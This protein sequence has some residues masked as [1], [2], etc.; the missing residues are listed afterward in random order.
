MLVQIAKIADQY[1]E[2][3]GKHLFSPASR[4]PVVLPQKDE[5]KNQ[6]N[7]STTEVCFKCNARAHKAVNYPSLVKK[8]FV[9]G[10][11][12]QL[13]AGCLVQPPEV[14]P[15]EEEVRACIK[16]DKPLLASGKK[17]PIISNACLEPLSGDQL[18]MPVVKGRVGEK[19]V[20][21]LRDPGC[22]GIIVKKN[23]VSEDQ[24]TGDFN[25]MLLIDNTAR[26]VPIARIS[27]DTPYLKGQAEAQCLPDAIYELIIGNFSGARPQMNQTQLGKKHAL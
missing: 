12:G 19:T 7:E 18:K 15:T 17:I 14:K 22:S 13:N 2:A 3:R 5:T 23:L 8:C 21:V 16:D 25:V 27:V 11:Q 20:D 10:K 24:F 1:L 26:K 6:Q 9:C 4:K